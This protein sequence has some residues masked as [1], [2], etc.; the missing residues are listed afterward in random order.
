MRLGLLVIIFVAVFSFGQ[1]IEIHSRLASSNLFG[2]EMNLHLR[3]YNNSGKKL[4][5]SKTDL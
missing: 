1:V 2:N 3:I 5:L 4:D